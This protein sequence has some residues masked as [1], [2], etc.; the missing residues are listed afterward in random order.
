LFNTLN[1]LLP[2][3]LP[4][5]VQFLLLVRALD[6]RGADIKLLSDPAFQRNSARSLRS[7]VNIGPRVLPLL[8]SFA[9]LQQ[10]SQ[11]H[12]GIVEPSWAPRLALYA[13]PSLGG[14]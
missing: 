2:C 7:L 8:P 6:P 14:S 10:A 9:N 13:K 12:G 11:R 1:A 4:H 5:C 3:P